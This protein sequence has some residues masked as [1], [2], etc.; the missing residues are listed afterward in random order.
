M[1]TLSTEAATVVRNAIENT[2]Q[3]RRLYKDLRRILNDTS[4]LLKTRA[5]RIVQRYGQQAATGGIAF[6]TAFLALRPA[7]SLS[8]SSSNTTSTSSTIPTPYFLATVEGTSLSEFNRLIKSLPD[9]GSGVQLIYNG[10]S[11]QGYITDLDDVKAAWVALLPEVDFILPNRLTNMELNAVIP[12][13]KTQHRRALPAPPSNNI[14]FQV[15]PYPSPNHLRL[16]AE[17]PLYIDPFNR[18]ERYLYDPI[19]GSGSTIY[20]LDTGVFAQSLVCI[21]VWRLCN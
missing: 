6:L 4:Q 10:V 5:S 8:S 1:D 17:G 7:A 12:S 2:G 18:L 11:S 19:A 9:E 14:D 3:L 21:C 16:V 15:L 20:V 13:K